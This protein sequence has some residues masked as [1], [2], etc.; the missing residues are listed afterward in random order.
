MVWLKQT[1]CL[2]EVREWWATANLLRALLSLGVA[3]VTPET[4]INFAL[5][6]VRT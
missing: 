4:E 5:E 6:V 2:L 1:A 3:H